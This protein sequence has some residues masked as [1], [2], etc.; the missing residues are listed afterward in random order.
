MKTEP[1]PLVDYSDRDPHPRV[2]DLFYQRWSPRSLKKVDIS[3][4]TLNAIFDAA[5]WSP[6]C[7]NEQPWLFI[8]SSNVREFEI[9]HSL[10]EERNQRWAI[11]ASVI[12]FLFGKRVFERN[13]KNNTYS[14]FDCGAACLAISL[15]AEIFD[16]YVHTLAGIHKEKTY[17]ALKV[18]ENNYEIICGFTIG[19][20]DRPEKLPEDLAAREKPPARRPLSEMWR[21][22]I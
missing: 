2:D 21:H 7:S 11:N 9:C 1:K 6:S 18:D 12:G 15:Q 14:A 8:T 13:G 5:R 4:D 22:G 19:A 20:L 17:N 3:N 16:L 10:L